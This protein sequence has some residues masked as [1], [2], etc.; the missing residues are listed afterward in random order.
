MNAE[1]I[2]SILSMPLKSVKDKIDN[3]HNSDKKPIA[4]CYLYN[5]ETD[6]E[7]ETY[8]LPFETATISIDHKDQPVQNDKGN[9]LYKGDCCCPD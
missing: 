5:E 3:Y 1:E 7:Q 9:V 6:E 2:A 8:I 4:G